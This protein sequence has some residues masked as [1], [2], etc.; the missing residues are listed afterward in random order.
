MLHRFRLDSAQMLNYLMR[1]QTLDQTHALRCTYRCC[2]CLVSGMTCFRLD[3]SQLQIFIS[4]HQEICLFF[5]Q[6][7]SH[8]F[9]ACESMCSN[10][11]IHVCV[12]VWVCGC[13]LSLCL[14]LSLP[15]SLSKTHTHAHTH[16]H[17]PLRAHTHIPLRVQVDLRPSR[18]VFMCP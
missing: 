15:P 9:L 11:C 8:F 4:V 5:I 1:G 2:R 12:G 3:S 10:M 16:T 6:K 7:K 13:I 17:T 14:C 18:Y